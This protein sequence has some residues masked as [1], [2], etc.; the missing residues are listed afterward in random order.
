[1]SR[2]NRAG[3]ERAAL[4]LHVH[5]P[6]S[7]DWRDGPIAPGELID[8]AVALGLKGIAVTDHATG[9]WVD[10]LRNAAASTGLIVFPGVELNNMAGNDGIHLVALFDPQVTASDIDR[11][12]TTVGALRGAGQGLR[13]GTATHGPLEVLDEIGKR[14]PT[15]TSTM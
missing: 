3:L 1:M 2:A 6:A 15:I 11:F 7:E 12:L 8:Q 10:E 14:P 4:D 9:A 5:T 13:R